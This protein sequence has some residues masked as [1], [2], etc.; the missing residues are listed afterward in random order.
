MINLLGYSLFAFSGSIT[1]GPNNIL[2]F[3]SGKAKGIKGTLA[4]MAGIFTGFSI[5]LIATGYGI[6]NI[7]EENELIGQILKI[8]ATLF[9][10][11]I[12]I[13]IRHIA[14]KDSDSPL[15]VN[16]WQAVLM[17]FVNIKAWMMALGG[18]ASFMPTYDNIHLNVFLFWLVYVIVGTC[19]MFIWAGLGEYIS[20]FLNNERR[21]RMAGN[22]LA[23][24]M[25]ASIAMIWI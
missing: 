5:I 11:Y 24:L 9:F 15:K 22:I 13:Q 25:L 23:L 17:Q 21:N 3:A 1:P 4:I 18:A 16:Y 12:A 2:L 10:L 8:I 14:I 20:K 7:L 6:A 19:C